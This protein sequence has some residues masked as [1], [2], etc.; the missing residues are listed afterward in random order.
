VSDALRF[1]DQVA[2][3][4]GAGGGLGMQYARLLASRGARVLVNDISGS[5]TGFGLEHR[6]GGRDRREDPPP[7]RR[8]GRRR[9]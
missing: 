8:G 1:D 9:A 5:V 6:C 3:I 2:M 7:R 4:T